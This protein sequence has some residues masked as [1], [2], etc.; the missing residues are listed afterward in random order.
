[1]GLTRTTSI[2]IYDDNTHVIGKDSKEMLSK[3]H[4]QNEE[5]FS[6]NENIV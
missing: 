5:Y 6:F 2:L 1:M 4:N 3:L